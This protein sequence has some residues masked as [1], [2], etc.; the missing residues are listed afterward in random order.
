MQH[1]TAQYGKIHGQHRGCMQGGPVLRR[2]RITVGYVWV[3]LKAATGAVEHQGDEYR[4]DGK[5]AAAGHMRFN[6]SALDG[7]MAHTLTDRLAAKTLLPFLVWKG[8]S[9]AYRTWTQLETSL[10]AAQHS[11]CTAGCSGGHVKLWSAAIM[12]HVMHLGKLCCCT[13]AART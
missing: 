10:K 9:P 6:Y 2:D 5:G 4:R 7:N 8:F 1:S 11:Q 12:A 3:L 13:L